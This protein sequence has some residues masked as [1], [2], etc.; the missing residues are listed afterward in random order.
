MKKILI[1]ISTTVC[2]TWAFAQTSSNPDLQAMINTENAFAK[3]AKDQNRRDA[4]LFYL[5]DNVV[6]FG[7]N[8]PV[9]GKENL[10]K[11]PVP[12]D[13][14]YWE[15]AYADIAASGD[16][17]YTTGPWEYRGKKSDKKP[18]AF[19]EFNSIW[20]KQ[21]DGS[22]K[23]ILDIGIE[24]GT[25]KEPVSLS[26]HPT[27]FNPDNNRAKNDSKALIDAEKKFIALSSKDGRGAYRQFLSARSR[28]C[29]SGFF[30]LVTAHE[31][32]Q[33]LLEK[34][35]PV[36][37]YFVDGETSSSDDLGYTYGTAEIN[38]TSSD[39]TE[40]KNASYARF[41]RKEAGNWKIVLDV[42]SH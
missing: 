24:H 16:F 32:E 20:K 11:Q 22:W 36:T 38:L 28:L 39:K 7:G 21:A 6:T 14:L 12:A 30:P 17:G 15:V 23:N 8:G 27:V 26:T 3:M 25:P 31:K 18:Q 29:H 19:G 37:F 41:W 42:L 33:F 10:R 1:L 2:A 40:K 13:W 35:Q 4:F 34:L 9:K 5:G